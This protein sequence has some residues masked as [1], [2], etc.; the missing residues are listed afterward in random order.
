[1]DISVILYWFIDNAL[2]SFRPT[3]V[4]LKF[5]RKVVLRDVIIGLL[6]LLVELRAWMLMMFSMQRCR[7]LPV[8]TNKTGNIATARH[9][10]SHVISN[11]VTM[12][13]LQTV[14]LSSANS[15]L[16]NSAPAAAGGGACSNWVANGGGVGSSR[17]GGTHF[18]KASK[19]SVIPG[20]AEMVCEKALDSLNILV[21]KNETTIKYVA[22]M[23]TYLAISY[24]CMPESNVFDQAALQQ[25]CCNFTEIPGI[26]FPIVII[27]A[28]NVRIIYALLKRRSVY[29]LIYTTRRRLRINI[30]R[31]Y[32]ILCLG[33]VFCF[34]YSP[35]C[36]VYI[37]APKL[38]DL[39]RRVALRYFEYPMHINHCCLF[40]VC[41]ITDKNFRFDA[42]RR[43]LCFYCFKH[44][45]DDIKNLNS[46]HYKPHR[47]LNRNV[48]VRRGT[49]AFGTS[50]R[51]RNTFAAVPSNV[52][53]SLNPPKNS[54]SANND[55]SSGG[56]YPPQTE[57]PL[58][59]QRQSATNIHQQATVNSF[60][61]ENFDWSVTTDTEYGTQCFRKT[62]LDEFLLQSF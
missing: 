56:L 25:L 51:I 7:S 19:P 15:I 49:T 22:E 52:S 61:S 17:P 39:T 35:R 8:S 14:G 37:F 44:E 53:T 10:P 41:L 45:N 55:D 34:T 20:Q 58:S 6:R 23:P 32:T 46:G 29:P 48:R 2:V 11:A 62:S 27:M 50:L 30:Q 38:S 16:A 4:Y 40:Y 24:P 18:Q 54:Q 60:D 47:A 5:W 21:A 28:T 42:C 3:W 26:L 59:K 33:I 36:F 9:N 43:L 13:A 57:T 1:M 31:A 12:G